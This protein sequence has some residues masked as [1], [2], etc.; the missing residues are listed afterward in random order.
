ME[1]YHLRSFVAVAQTGNLTQA[2]KRLYTTP[3]AIS[4]HIKTLEEELSTPLFIRSSKGMSLT[5]KGQLLLKKAQATLDSA[6]DFVNLAANNQH[7]IIG[8]FHLGINLTAKQIKLPELVE[9][10]QENC[11][12]I[13]LDIHQQ[14]T[15]KTINEIREHQ[16]DG[17]YIFGDIPDDFIGVAVMEQ[18]IT[19]V[20]P[21]TFDCSKIV[22][23]ADLSIHQWIMM[24]DYCPFDDFLKGIL[25]NDI[26]SVLK[27][28]D[29]GTRL[30]LV[31]SGLGLSL[32]E[33]EEALLAER[34]GK[35]QII[36]VLDFP[37]TLHFVIAKNRS[38][39]PVINTLMQEIRI[40]WR[41][42]L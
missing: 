13:S 34:T 10:L 29:D 3:P 33:I 27:T 8:T 32:L 31:K 9:N 18:Q 38:H 35:V 6:L 22:T 42:K 5:D 21:V 4:A 39:E 19:T 40:L 12:G 28:S 41:L 11:P 24:G 30:E 7:E 15:G 37:A 36:S 20:A 16:L 23:Q 2:A 14:S 25:G 1:F 17:G 26:P